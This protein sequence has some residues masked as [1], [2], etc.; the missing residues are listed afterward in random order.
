M[1]T[2]KLTLAIV[3]IAVAAALALAPSLANT[4]LAAKV[5]VCPSGN[6][7]SGQSGEHNPNVRC[8]AGAKG[9]NS[10]NCGNK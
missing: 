2:K 10:P 5:K 8:T 6:P 4:V 7:C 1:N 3:V 9:E